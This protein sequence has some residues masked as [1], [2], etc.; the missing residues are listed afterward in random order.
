MTTYDG[1]GR[2]VQSVDP[3]LAVAG[4]AAA[5]LV[6]YAAANNNNHRGRHNY[7]TTVSY[8]TYRSYDDCDY[9]GGYGGGYYGGGGYYSGYDPYY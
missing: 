1:Y 8:E 3:G 7:N 2:P 9:G 4:V 5:G 6:G